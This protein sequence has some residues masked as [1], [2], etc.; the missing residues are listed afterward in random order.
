MLPGSLRGTVLAVPDIEAAVADLR[1][2]GAID[3]DEQIQSAPW[4]RWV[5]VEDPDGNGWVVQQNTET[6]T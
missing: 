5:N 2:K 3:D 1:A 6:T 4:G